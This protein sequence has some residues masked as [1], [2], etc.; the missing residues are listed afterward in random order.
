MSW[1][2][3]RSNKTTTSSTKS[4]SNNNNN[5]PPPLPTTTIAS[6]NTT[7]THSSTNNNNTD[8]NNST[9][10]TPT[11]Q[12]S[13]PTPTHQNDHTTLTS[14]NNNNNKPTDRRASAGDGSSTTVQSVFFSVSATT[15][16]TSATTPGTSTTATKSTHSTPAGS[17]LQRMQSAGN[18]IINKEC[19]RDG[20]A[21]FLVAELDSMMETIT[22]TTTNNDDNLPETQAIVKIIEESSIFQP[23]DLSVDAQLRY[24]AALAN[25]CLFVGK[26]N[27][28]IIAPVIDRMVIP[29]PFSSKALILLL[30]SEYEPI[31][32]AALG[33]VTALESSHLLRTL[34]RVFRRDI[35]SLICDK[36]ATCVQGNVDLPA[37]I[38]M[39]LRESLRGKL[40]IFVDDNDSDPMCE[41]LEAGNAYESFYTIILSNPSLATPL[42]D[43]LT[44]LVPLG[45]PPSHYQSEPENEPTN[46]ARNWAAF[47][48][49]AKLVSLFCGGNNNNNKASTDK[50]NSANT[51]DL[52]VR[53]PVLHA[54]LTVYAAHPKNF[55]LLE[56][57][58]GVLSNLARCL[59]DENIH[60]EVLFMT[61][62]IFELVSLGLDY[63]PVT[64]LSALFRETMPKLIARQDKRRFG[65]LTGTMVKILERHPSVAT[66]CDLFPT[67]APVFYVGS[68][69]NSNNINIG[70]IS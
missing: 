48:V 68:G 54:V 47:A 17:T 19:P 9:I 26:T 60:D 58:F 44:A 36:L 12:T 23:G 37:S 7:P 67:L 28:E 41:S 1:F 49:V 57:P 65:L 4:P 46:E 3:S 16:T 52:T 2:F 6:N 66:D 18:I 8:D 59:G 69:N 42:L 14:I 24:F 25:I 13:S 15:T 31:R 35:A 33:A 70:V 61:I 55:G 27:E 11:T 32:I 40:S 53:L 39:F 64:A 20:E 43:A 29:G 45:G 63:R 62:K 22:T 56:R 5:T 34:P 50:S 30:S 21:L 38:P 10:G 51:P